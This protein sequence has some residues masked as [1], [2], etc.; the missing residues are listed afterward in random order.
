MGVVGPFILIAAGIF[1]QKNIA[2]KVVTFTNAV[3][4]NLAF[5]GKDL[6]SIGQLQIPL[7]LYLDIGLIMSVAAIASQVG[8]GQMPK[9]FNAASCIYCSVA[10]GALAIFSIALPYI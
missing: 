10:A 6:A 5:Y 7:I 2:G 1:I 4:M 9:E 8:K 3:A